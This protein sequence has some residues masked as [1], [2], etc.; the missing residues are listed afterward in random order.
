MAFQITGYSTSPFTQQ[1]VYSILCDTSA[2]LPA[3]VDGYA[4]AQG[5]SAT[6]IE[7]GSEYVAN[8]SGVWKLQPKSNQLDLTGYYTSA[9]TDTLLAGKQDSLTSAQIDAVNSGITSSDVVKIEINGSMTDSNLEKDYNCRI[10]GYASSVANIS[11]WSVVDTYILTYDKSRRLQTLLLYDAS[12]NV[13]YRRTRYFVS[14][15][16]GSW[17]TG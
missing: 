5:F 7:D 8:S 16:W 10:L 14:G 4:V 3:S 11:G 13:V 9:Q 1:R 15:S 2:D 12:N 6:I 17:I